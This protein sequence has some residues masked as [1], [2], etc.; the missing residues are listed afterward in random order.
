VLVDAA[1]GRIAVENGGAAEATVDFDNVEIPRLH[2][3][4][5]PPFA[6]SG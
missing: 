4:Q 5:L 3:A 6:A 2:S 1:N